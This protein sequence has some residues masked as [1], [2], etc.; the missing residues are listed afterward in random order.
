MA[1]GS[2]VIAPINAAGKPWVTSPRFNTQLD[3]AK[4]LPKNVH[5]EANWSTNLEPGDPVPEYDVSGGVKNFLGG[6]FLK[7]DTPKSLVDAQI[8]VLNSAEML[9]TAANEGAMGRV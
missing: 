4:I 5:A 7:T 2:V 1:V 8:T 6:V 9:M 3:W